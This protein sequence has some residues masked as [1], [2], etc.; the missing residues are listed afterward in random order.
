LFGDGS[1]IGASAGAYGLVAGFAALF[2]SQRLL[3]LMFFVIPISM[4]ARTLL[5]ISVGFSI[6]GILYPFLEPFVHRHFSL[7]GIID[8]M[9]V[10]IGHAAH[11]G[12]MATGFLLAWWIRRGIRMRRII[13]ISPKSSLNITHA[14]D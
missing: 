6:V 9:F 7:A 2:P 8:S 12:G 5:R 1:V 10:G 13:P 11:L 14:P 4:R 3:M